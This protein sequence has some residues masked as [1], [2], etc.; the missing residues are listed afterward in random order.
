ME[1]TCHGCGHFSEEPPRKAAS[2]ISELRGDEPRRRVESGRENED[3]WRNIRDASGTSECAKRILENVSL[4]GAGYT[5]TV[6]AVAVAGPEGRRAF[7]EQHNTSRRLINPWVELVE[8]DLKLADIP[9][10]LPYLTDC[11]AHW[12]IDRRHRRRSK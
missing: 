6:V 10:L 5:G 4:T 11:I 12:H 3:P 1:S 8:M 9:A 7:D 2:S